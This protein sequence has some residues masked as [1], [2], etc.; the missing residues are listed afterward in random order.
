MTTVTIDLDAISER[1]LKKLG[2]DLPQKTLLSAVKKAGVSASRKMRT[3]A[4]RIVRDEKD[5]KLKE[6]RDKIKVTAD[7]SG[8]AIG[9]MS[10]KITVDGTAIPIGDFKMRQ[11]KKGVKFKANKGGWSM[12]KGAFIATMK[13][14]HR[15]AF[16]RKDRTGGS[17][18]RY[19]DKDG[20]RQTKQLPI[21]ELYTSGMSAAF[22]DSGARDRIYGAGHDEFV[23]T[24]VRIVSAKL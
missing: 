10:W 19:K 11:L 18:V 4:T 24:F 15:G 13:N 14:G 8:S 2:G 7:T 22:K 1:E 5:L 20:N 17:R 3:E 9:T 6:V 12:F 21:K 23:K 16:A